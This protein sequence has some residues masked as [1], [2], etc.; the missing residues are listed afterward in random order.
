VRAQAAWGP[1]IYSS[2]KTGFFG[3]FSGHEGLMEIFSIFFK[4]RG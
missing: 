4:K 2:P 1:A 3:P